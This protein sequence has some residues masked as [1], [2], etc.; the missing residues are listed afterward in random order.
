MIFRKFLDQMRTPRVT[1]AVHPRRVSWWDEF[2]A[3]LAVRSVPISDPDA[4][5]VEGRPIAST[6]VVIDLREDDSSTALQPVQVE[7]RESGKLRVVLIDD[8]QLIREGLRRAFDRAGDIE[9]VGEA[10][11]IAEALSALDRLK[12]D[13]LVTDVRLP[14]GD[15][16]T[17]TTQVRAG[18]PSMGIVVLT[19]YAG[20]DQVFAALDAGASGFVGKDA[21]AEEVVAAARHAAANPRAF[22]ARD[23]AGAMQRRMSAP[24]GPKLS[25]REREVL[26]LLVDG[27]A[28]AQIARRL[29]I[30]ESTAKTHVANI[31]EKLGAG[32][33]AQ[34]VIAAA[35]LGIIDEQRIR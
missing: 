5:T 23:L 31:Y 24:A 19:M 33:R 3:A 2:T 16:I 21:P 14:D 27:L 25:P 22:T 34:A 8:H 29:Y 4:A 12:P 18:N 32:N 11:S 1:G 35:R 28:I 9:V 30:S 17:L 7:L 26:D 10:A 13:V 6:N 20:D 15:G